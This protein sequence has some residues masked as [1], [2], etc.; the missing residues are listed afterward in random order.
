ML[1]FFIPHPLDPVELLSLSVLDQVPMWNRAL[2]NEAEVRWSGGAGPYSFAVTQG[3][4]EKKCSEGPF[5]NQIDEEDLEFGM[6]H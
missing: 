6:Q 2:R 5:A 1:D 3:L 4:E